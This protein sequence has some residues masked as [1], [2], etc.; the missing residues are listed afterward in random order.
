MKCLPVNMAAC[1]T[2]STYRS[3]LDGLVEAADKIQEL[4]DRPRVHAVETPVPGLITQQ[5][6][7]AL[8]RLMEKIEPSC[9]SFLNL[10]VACP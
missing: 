7:D 5:K 2:T 1:L 6:P 4:Y 9:Q 8:I 3:S 10:V